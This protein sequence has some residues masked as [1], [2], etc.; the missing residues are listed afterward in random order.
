MDGSKIEKW[1]FFKG[2]EAKV[3]R[4]PG[5]HEGHRFRRDTF[6]VSF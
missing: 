5:Y 4:I 1:E 3:K 2:N 6:D